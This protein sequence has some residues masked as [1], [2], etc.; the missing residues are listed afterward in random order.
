[1]H[2]GGPDSKV[3]KLR[4]LMDRAG[5]DG[6]LLTLQKN[7]SWFLEGR[8]HVSLA[9]ETACCTVLITR[10]ECMLI[11][12]TIEAQRMLEEECGA[13]DVFSHV[14]VWDWYDPR[15]KDERL[16]RLVAGSRVK[17]DTELEPDLLSIRSVLAPE[18]IGELR[19][20]GKDTS[21]AVEDV[22]FRM[23]R[24]ETEF[25]I[26]GRL[27]AACYDRGMEPVVNLVAADDRMMTRRHPLPTN[28]I[29][30]ASAMIVVCARRNGLIASATR[31]VHFGEIPD[32]VS[33]KMS[34]VV[35]I[36]ARLMDASKPGTSLGAIFQEMMTF[37]KD[38]GYP[39]EYRLHHQG[40]L[41]G[42]ATR[43]KI[44][45]VSEGAVV[46]AHQLF[47]WNP[48]IAG[49]K[50]EDTLF[51]LPQGNAILTEPIQYPYLEVKVNS[52]SYKRPWILRRN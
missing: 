33:R 17:V 21:E 1:M 28:K 30:D 45:T 47:A 48:S 37:Y 32:A 16:L 34:A 27:A 39:E 12:N 23:A 51:V 42:Y 19:E 18:R 26:A 3:G 2:F 29:L 43:E 6:V 35:E 11:V 40:G 13:G 24:G 5:I 8:T 31:L 15:Q 22:A 25:Q 44:A 4:M 52:T 49:V 36:D 14:E 7:V 41:T 38:A 46:Q 20:L 50:S 10:G 9:S